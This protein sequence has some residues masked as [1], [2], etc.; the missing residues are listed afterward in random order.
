[1]R[2]RLWL[3]VCGGGGANCARGGKFYDL[4]RFHDVRLIAIGK[5]SAP[6][7][8]AICAILGETLNGGIVVTKKGYLN[9]RDPIRNHFKKH[10]LRLIEAGHPEPDSQS[11][12]AG[13]AIAQIARRAG[14]NTLLICC[15]SGGASALAILPTPGI[16]LASYRRVNQKTAQKRRPHWFDQCRAQNHRP[17]QRRR[18][19]GARPS[20]ANYLPD[21]VR[22]RGRFRR[23]NRFR[24]HRP[25][26]RG[27]PDRGQ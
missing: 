24:S 17:T 15:V 9:R 21:R 23:D 1:M 27:Q 12:R 18:I 22:C 26:A 3:P 6:M 14:S 5:A 7:A 19:G 16:S 2:G 13:R 20:R 11:L 8:G 4:G 25:P 10:G